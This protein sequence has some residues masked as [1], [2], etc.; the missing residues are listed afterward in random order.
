MTEEQ[1]LQLKSEIVKLIKSI[2]TPTPNEN[3]SLVKIKLEEANL[4]LFQEI[5]EG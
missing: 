1:K 2:P 3:I 5:V 4:W